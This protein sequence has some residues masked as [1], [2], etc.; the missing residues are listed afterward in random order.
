VDAVDNAILLDNSE[1]H[2]RAIKVGVAWD[3][4]WQG[5]SGAQGLSQLESGRAGERSLCRAASGAC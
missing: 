5:C 2:G 3:G 1:L 4:A